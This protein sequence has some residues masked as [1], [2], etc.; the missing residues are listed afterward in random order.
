MSDI[1]VTVVDLRVSGIEEL[2]AS[3][4]A[5]GASVYSTDG[6]VA[7]ADGSRA[8]VIRAPESETFLE[9]RDFGD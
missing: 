9:L 2:S 5:A 4:V 6:V 8:V 1:N 3:L 7:L